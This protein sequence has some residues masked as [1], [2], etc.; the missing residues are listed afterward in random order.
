MD[1]QGS[2]IWIILKFFFHHTSSFSPFI[3]PEV[4]IA[5]EKSQIFK[6]GMKRVENKSIFNL[7]LPIWENLSPQ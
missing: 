4:S 1:H 5:L 2:P 6:S 7:W 3:Q